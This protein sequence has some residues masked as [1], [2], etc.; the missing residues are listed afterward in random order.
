MSSFVRFFFASVAV[1]VILLVFCLY[2]LIFPKTQCG[3]YYH[4]CLWRRKLNSLGVKE[5]A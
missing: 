4:S 5:G 2:I 3:G 1:I